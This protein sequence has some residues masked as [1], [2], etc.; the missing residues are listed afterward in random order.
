MI[1]KTKNL[2]ECFTKKNCKKPNQKE[3]RVKKEIKR[4][5]DK[6]YVIWKGYDR[7]FNS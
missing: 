1:S 4:K 6:L 3:F 7:L 2:L 5:S